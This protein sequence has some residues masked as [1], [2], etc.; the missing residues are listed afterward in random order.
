MNIVFTGAAVGSDGH[1]IKREDIIKASKM[2]GFHVQAKVD[3]LTDILVASRDDTVKAK[4][5]TA[6]GVAVV[7]YVQWFTTLAKRGVEIGDFITEGPGNAWT[8]T[9][10]PKEESGEVPDFSNYA[11]HL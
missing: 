1:P 7:T 8:D 6:G 3:A 4:N 11:S 5:A 10:I 9:A 2:A